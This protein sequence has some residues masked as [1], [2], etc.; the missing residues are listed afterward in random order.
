M[1]IL[2]IVGARPQ[3]IKAAMLS[4]AVLRHNAAHPEAPVT[5][6]ILHTGQHYDGAMSRVFSSAD[7]R[8]VNKGSGRLRRPEDDKCQM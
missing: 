5:E 4:R 1:N 7:G 3:F 2:T 8:C 6:E